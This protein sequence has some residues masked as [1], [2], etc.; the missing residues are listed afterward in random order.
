MVQI[1]IHD[2]RET[3]SVYWLMRFF[4]LDSWVL[5]FDQVHQENF[6]TGGGWT[7]MCSLSS[8][9]SSK[10][11]S[12]WSPDHWKHESLLKFL[13]ENLRIYWEGEDGKTKQRNCD[14][15]TYI[16][17]FPTIIEFR[18]TFAINSSSA[19]SS[20]LWFVWSVFWT[21]SKTNWSSIKV[22]RASSSLSLGAG[23]SLAYKSIWIC[24]NNIT[25]AM[26]MQLF[27]K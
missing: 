14:V 2:I 24:I 18:N 26:S 13:A 21:L 23:V 20:S 9:F 5:T 16:E 25:N 10:M 1:K 15:E 12:P 19:S 3:L 7:I 4:N 17:L 8:C 6:T 11:Y 27:M 22:S